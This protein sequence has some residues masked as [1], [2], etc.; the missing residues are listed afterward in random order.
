LSTGQHWRS[1][2][3]GLR[4]LAV[5]MVLLFHADLP[6]PGGFTGV[7]V[8]FVVSG[9]VVTQMIVREYRSTGR[10]DLRAFFI[11]RF[12][13]LAP[14]VGALLAVVLLVTVAIGSPLETDT[15]T[16][17]TALGA[18]TLSA[19]FVIAAQSGDYFDAA[20]D[21]NPLLHLWS[22]AVEEQ[23]YL[24]FPLVFIAAT[25]GR[26][27]PPPRR[28][29][30]L[31]LATLGAVSLKLAFGTETATFF[32]PVA[33]GAP[34]AFYLLPA[35]AW[36]FLV[37]ALLALTARSGVPARL[38]VRRLLASV[39]VVGLI[40]GSVIVDPDVVQ[41][42]GPWTLLPV[43]ATAA[44]LSGSGAG[45]GRPLRS[46]PMV[47]LGDISYSL[48]L[49]HW[50]MVVF[51]KR[52][53]PEL[54]A[55]AVLAT[56]VALIPAAL[57]HR[58]LEEPFRRRSSDGSLRS[59]P[60]R[61]AVVVGVVIPLLL[62][63]AFL[64]GVS[65]GWGV[66]A[67][68]E[69]K[70]AFET[71]HIAYTSGC[72]STVP[73]SE[74][75]LTACWW[76]RVDGARSVVLIG[77]S[78]AEHFSGAVVE[79]AAQ[80]DRP[81]FILIQRGCPFTGAEVARS[82]S[83]LELAENGCRRFVSEALDILSGLEP[84]DVIVAFS[85][86]YWLEAGWFTSMQDSQPAADFVSRLAHFERG[87]A[88]T[89]DVLNDQGHRTVYVEAVPHLHYS[90]RLVAEGFETRSWS[91][92]A[93]SATSLV[94][95]RCQRDVPMSIVEDVQGSAWRAAQR[96]VASRTETVQYLSVRDR[97]CD[98]S[99]CRAGDESGWLYRDSTHLTVEGAGRTVE[100]FVRELER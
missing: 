87:L 64:S 23:F 5:L 61:A 89:L 92:E 66:P 91:I 72:A 98:P 4:G 93:C 3:Q 88:S 45:L 48:Y 70:E 1:D 78:N 36:E 100:A 63:T 82:L 33:G 51:A 21:L 15:R 22:L 55:I 10:V 53:W 16:G 85:D 42:P 44:V 50:P 2:V 18:L 59:I 90:G 49:W 75:D 40:I 12:Q 60:S 80:L 35:R 97:F 58:V 46:R 7:D 41:F 94:G 29:L 71:R 77:D 24:L 74:R 52:V 6:V 65:R 86:Q 84:S 67:L 17:L 54:P 27:R 69:A 79:A 57:S 81:V 32:S 76:D 19:N 47:W 34:V 28:V 38:E 95:G 99:A 43:L 73:P 8:F 9:F 31:L 39:G 30:G 14:A 26:R 20:S 83:A 25:L 68:Q 62:S 13:R 37:G 56:V 96:V 11:R